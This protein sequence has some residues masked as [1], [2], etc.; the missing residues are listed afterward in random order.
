[1]NYLGSKAK[2]APELLKHILKH[3]ENDSVPYV[4][5]FLGGGNS[6]MYVTGNRIGNDDHY[7]LMKM[8]EGVISGKFKPPL[9]VKKYEYACLQKA[10]FKHEGKEFKSKTFDLIECDP[11]PE[12]ELI[13][14][15]GFFS[16]ASKWF[17]GYRKNSHTDTEADT[18]KMWHRHY[19]NVTE[20]AKLLYGVKFHNVDYRQLL[21]SEGS[22]IYC[23][24]PYEGTT[25]Y[26]KKEFDHS[27]FWEWVRKKTKENFLIYVSEYKAPNDFISIWNKDVKVKVSKNG[28]PIKTTEHLFVHKNHIDS[29]VVLNE[30]KQLKLFKYVNGLTIPY[31]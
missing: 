28:I 7:F 13:G 11:N 3:R 1:M 10:A 20:Q 16:F 4:E 9:V 5:P 8:W 21:I 18:D 6:M 31:I 29:P 22:I 25:Q 17:G 30:S 23:D 2:I 27:A 12:P 26:S 24:P 15:A 19:K 14:Y